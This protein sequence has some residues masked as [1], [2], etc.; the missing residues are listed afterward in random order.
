MCVNIFKH[1]F[2]ITTVETTTYL[3]TREHYLP[4][5]HPTS[6]APLVQSSVPSHTSVF[7]IH[8]IVHVLVMLTFPQK[9]LPTHEAVEH[10][11]LQY[12]K[13]KDFFDTNKQEGFKK[14]HAYIM[15][16]SRT[17]PSTTIVAKVNKIMCFNILQRWTIIFII[18]TVF[19]NISSLMITMLTHHHVSTSSNDIEE[20]TSN[21]MQ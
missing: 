13:Y 19:F 10:I 20:M 16:R 21:Y 1:T 7:V 2:K 18:V 6:S 11:R 15:W 9:N 3:N 12:I 5:K 14:I 17:L 8:S 4:V